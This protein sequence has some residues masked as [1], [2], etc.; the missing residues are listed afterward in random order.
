MSG[1][2][3]TSGG[4][5]S[6]GSTFETETQLVIV[7]DG[8]RGAPGAQGEPGPEGP[9]GDSITIHGAWVAGVTYC[10]GDAVTDRS[11]LLVGVTSLYIQKSDQPC[12]VSNTP[13]HMDPA[14][15]MEV[16]NHDWGNTFG[17]IW[18]VYQLD[19][20][21]TKIGQPVGF[22]WQAER[23]VQASATAEDELGIA[24]V[25]EII[26][27]D[28]VVLQSTGE[29]PN[30]DP[31]VIYP[32][33]STWQHGRVYYVSTA[34]GR[35]ELQPPQFISGI[36]NPVLMAA[37]DDPQTGGVNGIALPW[38]PVSGVKEYVPVGR[39]KF[40]FTATAGQIE[41]SGVDNNGNT[42]AYIPGANTDVF[43]NG[44]NLIEEDQYI[45]VDGET[46]TFPTP[47]SAGDTV[48]VW[49]PDR[50]LD[51]LV[52]STLLKLDNIDAQ[53][54]GV[55]TRFELTYG[56][57]P[58]LFQSASAAQIWL[59]ATAQEAEVDF[60]IIDNGTFTEVEFKDAPEEGTRFWGYAIQPAPSG[61]LGLPDGGQAGDVLAKASS[62]DGDAVWVSTIDGGSW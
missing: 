35:L 20:S 40:Y 42:L 46:I 37:D 60:T 61:V 38:T 9:Q 34:R 58:I 49:T 18:E 2:N 54:D 30:I 26:D 56:G 25:R 55:Q 13:P 28:R 29:V 21:F 16:S 50:P 15:W 6:S 14:R 53:F 57:D 62:A 59:D 44:L 32:D 4:S 11:T 24:V 19:H 12:G 51:I 22:S 5:T 7:H 31:T 52:Q 41:I 8:R 45:A 17:G 36:A 1:Y 23:Y 27:K 47:L 3:I 33:G 10:P 48:E 39:V 43:V